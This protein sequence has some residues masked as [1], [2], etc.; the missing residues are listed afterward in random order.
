MKEVMPIAKHLDEF[1]K[2]ILDLKNMDIK[3]EDED[4]TLILLCSLSGLFDNF[5]N[6]MLYGRDTISIRDVKA[7][8]NS[9]ELRTRLG[10]NKGD[11]QAEGLFVKGCQNNS[12][13][14]VNG[15]S[16][17]RNSDSGKGKGRS[18]SK[19]NKKSV[20]YHYCHKV[21]HYKLEHWKLKNKKKKENS[22]SLVGVAEKNT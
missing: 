17:E 7:S 11:T 14:Q 16:T 20:E 6:S 13:N 19:S 8:M 15:R 21:G 10:L 1:N 5:V 18:Q 9:K 3:L 2:I 22:S 12:S 4:Q